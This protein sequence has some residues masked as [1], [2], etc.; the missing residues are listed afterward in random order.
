MDK[1]AEW[2]LKAANRGYDRAIEKL[3]V[4]SG[5]TTGFTSGKTYK[6]NTR[7]WRMNFYDKRNYTEALK[8]YKLVC[9]G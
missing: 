8:Y 2:Y 4:L 3:K 5:I 1:A 9:P 6:R 7:R